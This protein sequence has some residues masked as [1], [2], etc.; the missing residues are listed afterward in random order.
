[1]SAAI[2]TCGSCG[3]ERDARAETQSQEGEQQEPVPHYF[4][5][6]GGTDR[7]WSIV[8]KWEVCR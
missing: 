2:V 1:M 4:W 6:W 8:L 7:H 5:G 3:L